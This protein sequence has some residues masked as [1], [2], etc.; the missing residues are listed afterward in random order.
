MTTPKPDKAFAKKYNLEGRGEAVKVS[1][2]IDETVKSLQRRG[3]DIKAKGEEYSK[4]EKRLFGGVPH[5]GE[6]GYTNYFKEF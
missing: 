5:P 3:A 6:P 4:A 1:R 2:R